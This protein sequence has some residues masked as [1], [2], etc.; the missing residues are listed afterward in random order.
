MADRIHQSRWQ[1]FRPSIEHQGEIVVIGLGRF[2]S[3][4]ASTLIKVGVFIAIALI[5]KPRVL[6][7]L[8]REVARTGSREL[9][10]LAVLAIALGI[11]FMAAELFGV[12]FALSAFFSGL[13]GP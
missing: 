4:M 5:L 7:W 10:T 13:P 6:Q 9:F 8:L 2:G 1:G 11:A 12:S 3:A